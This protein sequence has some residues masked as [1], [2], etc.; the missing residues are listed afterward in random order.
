MKNLQSVE[1]L[2]STTTICS[3]K[4][5][6]LT[7][8]RM[9]VA[10]LFYDGTIYSADTSLSQ[11]AY[12]SESATFHELLRIMAVSN[13]SFFDMSAEVEGVDNPRII[14]RPIRGSPSEAALTKF[15]QPIRDVEEFRRANPSIERAAILFNSTN[16]FQVTI[17]QMEQNPNRLIVMMKGAP[18]RILQR[19]GS[20]MV[21]GELVDMNEEWSQKVEKANETLGG[22]GERVLGFCLFYLDESWSPDSEFVIEPEPNYPIDGMCFMGLVSL[23]DPPRPSVPEA[24][25]LCQLAGIRVVMVT[26]DHPTTAKAIAKQ[27]N[28]IRDD[29]V[30]DIAIR[31]GIPVSQ[32]DVTGVKAIVVSGGQLKDMTDEELDQVLSYEQIVFARTSPQQKMRI[33]EGFQR[34]HQIVAVTGDGV[35]DSPALKKADI[36]IAM[37]IAGSQVSKEA[38]DMILRDDNFASIVKGVE[39]GRLIF[40]NLKKSIAYTLS[41]KIPET[42]PFICFI[43]LQI[44]L[45]LETV[46]ILCVDVGTDLLPAISL[47]YE[48]AE[49]DIMKRRPRNAQTDRLVTRKLISYS[50]LQIGVIQA[51][52]GFYSYIVLMG[53]YGFPAADLLG[54]STDFDDEDKYILVNNRVWDFDDRDKVLRRAQTS[55]FVTIVLSQIADLMV[56]KTR[57]LSMFHQGMRNSVMNTGILVMF[58]IATTLTYVPPLNEGLGTVPL[59]FVQWLHPIP[60]SIFIFCYDEFRKYLIRKYP[61]G[62]FEQYTYY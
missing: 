36:G 42:M 20:I 26:G 41:S 39:E 22:M 62:W 14:D 10:H 25:R 30:E 49:A 17:H 28:I 5:G 2:G 40:D 59:R 61:G 12:N 50:Y 9:T 56:S 43:I 31:Q 58:V 8:N 4:T 13:K 47:S 11:G 7:Q 1:T 60:F 51:V 35:N 52:A 16:K 29:T 53:D 32:V 3:D 57:K 21:N 19:C 46:L 15:V 44:P 48:L 23:I 34:Q 54:L 24:V 33:V 37:G 27:V 6:T 55:Y 38:A 18:E 45:P